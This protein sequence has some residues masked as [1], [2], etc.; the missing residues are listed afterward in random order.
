MAF[1]QRLEILALT[2]T[3]SLN[4]ALHR[5][6]I[7]ASASPRRRRILQDAGLQFTIQVSEAEPEPSTDVDPAAFAVE[8]AERKA[9]DVAGHHRGRLVLGADTIVVLD[10]RILGKPADERQAARMLEELS[11]RKHQVIT[12]FA[13]A[14][15][16]GS[17]ARI[18]E[19]DH[20]C[21]GAEFRELS[22][23]DIQQYVA[24]GEPMGKAGSYA[25]QSK[26]GELIR[27][28][29]GSYLNVVGLPVRR[30]RRLLDHIGYQGPDSD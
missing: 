28:V 14:F 6:L 13:L 8:A 30:I 17:G 7:L 29:N 27:R 3:D 16:D 4:Q 2:P 11:G 18:I 15:N 12:G 5:P 25:I 1:D 23:K 21:S 22:E 26:G 20:E 10:E 19:A 24:T 9:L